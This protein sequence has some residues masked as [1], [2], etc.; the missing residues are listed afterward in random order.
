MQPHRATGVMHCP[1]GVSII[2]KENTEAA[3]LRP[4]GVTPAKWAA[5]EPHLDFVSQKATH[6]TSFTEYLPDLVSNLTIARQ[7]S[8]QATKAATCE[9]SPL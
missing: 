2:G 9:A 3:L 4:L 6:F 5:A 8:Q 1:R 7:A